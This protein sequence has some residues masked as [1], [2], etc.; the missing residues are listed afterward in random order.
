MI[1]L[2]HRHEVYPRLCDRVKSVQQRSITF[3]YGNDGFQR[4]V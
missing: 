2:S 1:S 3:D 4:Q